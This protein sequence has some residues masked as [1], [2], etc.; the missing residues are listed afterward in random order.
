MLD[1]GANVPASDDPSHGFWLGAVCASQR[2]ILNGI[3]QIR[4]AQCFRDTRTAKLYSVENQNRTKEPAH[5]QHLAT[6]GSPAKE[7]VHVSQKLSTG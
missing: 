4:C 2:P 3:L 5:E 7:V 6:S 1:A